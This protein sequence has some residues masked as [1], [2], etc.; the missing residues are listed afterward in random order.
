MAIERCTAKDAGRI[1]EIIN[2]AAQAYRG[3]IPAD[4]WHEP[5]MPAAELRTEM[6]AGVRFWGYTTDGRIEAV[7]GLQHV[8]DV[9][10][11]RHAYTR[12]AVRGKGFGGALL[13]HLKRE[14]TAPLLVG[15]WKA[16]TWAVHFY[17]KRGFTLV[18]E[19]EKVRLLNRY[20][21]VPG[22][23]VEESV[24]LRH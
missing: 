15:T 24:V 5:Y 9:A 19:D 13:E 1:L 21:K 10:L 18:E 3:V 11:I 6:D 17:E 22:R 16:A 7:M 8:A 23:Q 12:T 14:A 20:W 2:D 4:R